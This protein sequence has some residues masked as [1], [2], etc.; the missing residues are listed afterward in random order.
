MTAFEMMQRHYHQRDLAAREWKNKGG[1][2]VGYFCNSV[3]EEL[4]LAAG[5]FPLRISG[6]PWGSSEE[7]VKFIGPFY[8]EFVRS[9]LSMIL[10]GKYDFLDFIIIPRSK[11]SIAEQYTH[12]HQIKYLEPSV[13]LPEIYL[14]DLMHRRSYMS[15]AYDLDRFRDLKKKL[16][17]WSGRQITP[18][19]LS[20]SLAITNENR[21]LLKDMAALR[22]AEQPRISGMEALQII[23]SSMFMLKEE[24]NKLLKEFLAGAEK[25]PVREGA[26]LFVEGSPLDNLQFY[27]LVESCPATVIAE[28]NCWGNRYS[29]NL[30]DTD[31][32][33]MEAIAGRYHLNSPCPYVVFPADLRTDYC[34]NKVKESKAQGVIFYIFEWDG[35]ATWDYPDQKSALE[36]EGVPT[37]LFKDQKYLLSEPGPLKTYIEKF[38]EA[39]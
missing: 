12:L 29:D 30:I 23:G 3:P 34:I 26:R 31:R 19:S 28:D 11:D 24:H 6:D 1:K 2:V 4:I 9:Q 33:P 15:G 21:E 36:K 35:G 16:E 32:D 7:I 22:T 13:E 25:L 37:V 8:E 39:I 27:N 18:Q 20:R 17:E 10:T 14:L 5:L 38:I